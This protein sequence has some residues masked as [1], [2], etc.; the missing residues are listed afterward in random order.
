MSKPSADR[1][2]REPARLIPRPQPAEYD[3]YYRSYVEAVPEGPLLDLLQRQSDELLEMMARI[4]DAEA[5]YRYA[6][7][8]WSVKEVV[9]HLCDAERVFAYRALAVARGDRTPLPGFDENRWVEVAGF[10]R[11]PLAALMA[12]AAR[13]RGATLSLLGSLGDEE[14]ARQGVANGSSISARALA[15]IIAGHER[16][17][18][19]VLVERYGLR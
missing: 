5:L 19:Q 6:A 1:R 11:Q 13:V 3:A 8:K 15:W 18:L 7:G 4:H 14:L 2:N 9:G 12:E 17:H 16:H 10:D